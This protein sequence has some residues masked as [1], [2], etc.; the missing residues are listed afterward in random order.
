MQYVLYRGFAHFLGT[1][2]LLQ[3]PTLVGSIL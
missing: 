2:Q 1:Y 3:V